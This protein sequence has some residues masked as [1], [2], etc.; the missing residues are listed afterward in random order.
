MLFLLALDQILI[1][2]LEIIAVLHS[3]VVLSYVTNRLNAEQLNLEPSTA[4]VFCAEKA[5]MH[6][7]VQNMMYP[8]LLKTIWHL[9]INKTRPSISVLVMPCSTSTVPISKKLRLKTKRWLLSANK[10]S[11]LK[12]CMTNFIPRSL[13]CSEYLISNKTYFQFWKRKN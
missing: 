6:L 11:N 4:N 9:V 1:C 7:E 10:N 12:L 13:F 8:S 3:R 5:T 2:I